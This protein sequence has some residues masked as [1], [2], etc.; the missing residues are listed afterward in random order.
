MNISQI[1][2][3]RDGGSLNATYTLSL[4]YVNGSFSGITTNLAGNIGAGAQVFSTRVFSNVNDVYD[5]VYNAVS[6]A[7]SFNYDPTQG[8]LLMRIVQSNPTGSNGG[9]FASYSGPDLARAYQWM[10]FNSSSAH[11]G[12]GITAQFIGGPVSNSGVPAPGA[13]ALMGLGLLGV[14]AVRRRKAA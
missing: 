10:N 4:S 11:T 3:F 14:G 13:L 12:Y 1:N 6:F 9:S 8:D 7:G 5:N 2:F